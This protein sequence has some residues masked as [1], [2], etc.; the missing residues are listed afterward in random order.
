[1]ADKVPQTLAARN[2]L[3]QLLDVAEVAKCLCA[4][5]DIAVPVAQNSGGNADG[6]ATPLIVDDE[7]AQVNDRLTLLQRA[8]QRAGAFTEIGSEH[9]AAK[10]A[11]GLFPVY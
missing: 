9:L 5:G 6:Q 2:L 4:A 8:S 10:P 7:A 1:M 3:A 11:D